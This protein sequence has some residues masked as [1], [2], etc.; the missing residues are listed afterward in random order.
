MT[1]HDDFLRLVVNAG[2]DP[3][4]ADDAATLARL[5]SAVQAGVAERLPPA[6]RWALLAGALMTPRPSACLAALRACG[7]LP[8][9]LPELAALYG[10]PQLSDAA[11]PV[12]VGAHQARLVDECAAAALPLATRFAGLMHKLGKGATPRE[13]WPSHHRHEERGQRLLDGLAARLAVP[14]DA[15]ALARLA[16]DELDRLH[17]AS[18]KR[19]GAMTALLLRLDAPGQPARFEQ[20]L[21]LCA[22][23][24]A[25][26]DGHGR[27]DYPKAA[28]W[29]RALA[30][31]DGLDAPSLAGLD[32]DAAL[33]ARAEAVARALGS[34][35]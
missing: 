2:H 24:Y 1:L 15:L 17:R 14:A 23:D 21:Q 25:A 7:A 31:M 34:A 35:G 30:A 28:R 12:D 6:A 27:D 3:T 11:L 33:Q 9:L 16:I 4:L 22:C 20:L 8:R 13:I 10:V 29:R 18:D 26:H 32:E 5:C 19:A